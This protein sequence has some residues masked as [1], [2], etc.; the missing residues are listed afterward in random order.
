MSSN[1]TRHCQCSRFPS[2]TAISA[3]ERAKQ[4]ANIQIFKNNVLLNCNSNL[5]NSDSTRRV[6]SGSQNRIRSVNGFK[7]TSQKCEENSTCIFS[8]KNNA[9][10]WFLK[11]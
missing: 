4:K 11:N 3:S 2:G 5:S 9:D 1:N 10:F 6:Y 7:L 8:D